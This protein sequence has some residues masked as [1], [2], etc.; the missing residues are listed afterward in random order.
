VNACSAL[1]Y[2]TAEHPK[3]MSAMSAILLTVGALPAIP[4]ISAGAGGALLA[5]G[6]AQAVGAV[7]MAVG[8]MIKAQHDGQ[9]QIA[10]AA[11]G[12]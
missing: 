4:A 2:L 9:L 7:A 12:H 5:S 10:N 6:A 8:Q 1:E 3:A 11:A